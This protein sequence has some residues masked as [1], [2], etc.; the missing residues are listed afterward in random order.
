MN[1]AT[2]I[3]LQEQAD[4]YAPDPELIQ[5]DACGQHFPEEETQP[6]DDGTDT[7]LI[8]CLACAAIPQDAECT[9]QQIDVD[10][11]DARYCEL[12]NGTPAMPWPPERIIPVSMPAAKIEPMQGSLFSQKEVA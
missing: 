11:V 3:D 9:C 8:C 12:H 5:C 7:A 1:D 6:V 10:L 2:E 4:F